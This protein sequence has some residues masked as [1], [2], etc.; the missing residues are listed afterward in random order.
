M[1]VK[2]GPET[3]V[4]KNLKELSKMFS[5]FCIVYSVRSDSV[6]SVRM[7]NY[8]NTNKLNTRLNL[9]Q[10]CIMVLFLAKI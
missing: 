10:L 7:S 3:L 2:S 8:N 9:I 4:T 5:S 1:D 6:V